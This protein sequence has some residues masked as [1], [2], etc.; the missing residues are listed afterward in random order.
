[1]IKKSRGKGGKVVRRHAACASEFDYQGWKGWGVWRRSVGEQVNAA[2][3][4]LKAEEAFES[5][6]RE[7]DGPSWSANHSRNGSAQRYWEKSQATMQKDCW[8][9][10]DYPSECRWGKQYGVKTPTPTATI[11]PSPPTVASLSS[12]IAG[13]DKKDQ[14]SERDDPATSFEEILLSLS[15]SA[16]G[17]S[18]P[19]PSPSSSSSPSSPSS[20]V[21]G[22][23]GN[24]GGDIADLPIVLEEPLLDYLEPLSPR[25]SQR[26][27]SVT[28]GETPIVSM[29]DLLESVKRRKRRSSGQ[30]PSPLGANPPSPVFM[31]PEMDLGDGGDGAKLERSSS[32][33]NAAV[34]ARG[35]KHS[36]VLGGALQRAFDDL[37]VGVTS[38]GWSLQEKAGG[39]VRGLVVGSTK[40][41]NSH[42]SKSSRGKRDS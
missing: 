42:N 38:G 9:K 36:I 10:C 21:T 24:N 40:K 15:R 13:E 20:A 17:G 19:S 2:E 25:R 30:I 1:M 22:G 35:Q 28:E 32:A 6:F 41:K 16:T 31:E 29:D 3:A 5:A 26:Q 34:A 33:N 8:E 14:D 18:S 39:F 23:G 12:A 4:L 27:K 37:D 7:R 11:P